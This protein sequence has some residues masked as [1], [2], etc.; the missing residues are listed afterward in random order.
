[1]FQIEFMTWFLKSSG[2][3]ARRS[4]NEISF[5][6]KRTWSRNSVIHRGMSKH[7]A[8]KERSNCHTENSAEELRDH[9]EE[10]IPRLNLS[11]TEEGERHRRVH[12]CARLF[13]PPGVNDR[14]G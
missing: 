5:H 7:H 13:P 12:M 11:Q 10:S 3:V 2:S 1:M 9:V 14:H 6:T 8:K 4:G